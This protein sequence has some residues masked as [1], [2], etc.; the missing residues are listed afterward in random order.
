M[1]LTSP[2]PLRLFSLL[3]VIVFLAEAAVMVVL[4][5]LVTGA[6]HLPAAAIAD[7][8]LLVLLVA[9]FLWWFIVRPLRGTAMVEHARAATVVSNAAEGIITINDRGL[10]E[11]FNPAAEKI[12]GY[13][14]EEVTGKPLTLLI[15]GMY[16]DAH[17]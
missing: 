7:A 2:S 11:S 9:P 10:I 15:P 4:P 17:R 6:E 5:V 3:L 13:S 1:Q 16:R 8:L 12:F 14:A